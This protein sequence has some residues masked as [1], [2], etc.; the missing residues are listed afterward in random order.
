[1]MR[2]LRAVEFPNALLQDLGL[3]INQFSVPFRVFL[4]TMFF[5]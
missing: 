2:G 4:G 3:A 5:L 1:M